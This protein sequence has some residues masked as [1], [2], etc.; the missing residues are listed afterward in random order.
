MADINAQAGLADPTLLVDAEAELFE[1]VA[2]KDELAESTTDLAESK[3]DAMILGQTLIQHPSETSTD[4]DGEGGEGEK[5]KDKA[6]S[7]KKYDFE[8]FKPLA[9]YKVRMDV[10]CHREAGCHR[11]NLLRL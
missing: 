1:A 8:N 3:A 4:G 5:G 2:G 11:V 9:Y 10:G 7:D 6:K